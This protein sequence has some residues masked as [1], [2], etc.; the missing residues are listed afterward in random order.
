[1]EFTIDAKD[2]LSQIKLVDKRA[3]EAAE[4]AMND[5]V[6]ELTRIASEITPFDKG[7]LAK[8]HTKK[9]Q[10]NAGDVQAEVE[11]SVRE[12][13]FNYA[14]WIHEGIYNHGEG[15]MNRSG[16]TGWSG[17]YYYVGRK[18]LER[19]LKGEEQAFYEHIAN[20]IKQAVGE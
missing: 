6:D 5:V 7:T 4:V 15:T 1:M 18:Y 3:M 12:G 14:L 16:T 10:A 11:F 20:K 8:S 2:F 9:V 13:D 17:K 19:P